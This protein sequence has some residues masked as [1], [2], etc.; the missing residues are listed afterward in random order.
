MW[1]R[2][3]LASAKFTTHSWRCATGRTA[4]SKHLFGSDFFHGEIVLQVHVH[5]WS[6][7]NGYNEE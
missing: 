3:W 5:E 4:D 2:T 6:I 1:L 7:L